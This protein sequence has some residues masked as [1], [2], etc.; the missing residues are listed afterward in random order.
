MME[1]T[2]PTREQRRLMAAS[3]LQTA[4]AG[5]LDP[6]TSVSERSSRSIAADATEIADVL[7]ADLELLIE[8]PV[9]RVAREMV[10]P[11]TGERADVAAIGELTW[12]FEIKSGRD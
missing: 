7:V 10:V 8:A 6:A 12:L 4:P 9:R 3:P 11:I 2:L 1:T 5:E